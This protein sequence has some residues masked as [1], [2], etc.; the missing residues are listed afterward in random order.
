MAV[1]FGGSH[2]PITLS[3]V[4]WRLNNVNNHSNW[5]HPIFI[6]RACACA[7]TL[8]QSLLR[9][10][11][12]KMLVESLRDGGDWG[13]QCDRRNQGCVS[14]KED[15]VSKHPLLYLLEQTWSLLKADSCKRWEGVHRLQLTTSIKPQSNASDKARPD[16][17]HPV[18]YLLRLRWLYPERGTQG[19]PT[20]RSWK[21]KPRQFK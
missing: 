21:T 6:T 4:A 19:R 20:K 7:I 8:I 9:D 5:M 2:Y 10:N 13:G 1:T 18:V 15:H 16:V 17:T 3:N 11:W 12:T 14:Q